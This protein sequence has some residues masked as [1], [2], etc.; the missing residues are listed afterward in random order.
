M[1]KYLLKN[2]RL[3]KERAYEIIKAPVLT[4]KSNAASE[5]NKVTFNVTLDATKFEVQ[6]AVEEI[7]KVKVTAVNTL[8][9]KGKKKRFKGIV[10]QRSEQK[11]AIVTLA[12]GN[13]ID[14]A[15]GL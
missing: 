9:I 14:I 10:G 8:R 7:F 6:R 11:R 15:S 1:T 5:Q 13:S 12:A 2:T 3:S 4:E